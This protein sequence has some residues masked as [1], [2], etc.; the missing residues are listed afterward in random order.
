M[1]KAL[2]LGN[3]NILVG[4]DHVGQVRDFYFPYIG[5]ENQVGGH[6]VHR[7]GVYVDGTL[8]WLDDSSWEVVVSSE[9][10]SLTGVVRA[11]NRT[12]GVSL[13]TS[14]VVYNERN[15]F[16]RRVTIKNLQGVRR[17]IRLFFGQQFEL[18]E[19]HRAH[20][21]YYD[22]ATHSI[23]H[24]RGKRVFLINAR[25]DGVPFDDYSTG[26]FHAEGKEGTHRDAED[27]ILAKNP[28]EHG[29]ADSVIG[30]SAE[31]GPGES[32]IASYW[33]CVAKSHRYAKRL[34][35]QVLEK[36]PA[37]MM[38]TTQDYWKAWLNRQHFNFQG[39]SPEVISLFKKS[40]L[41]IRA[42]ADRGGALIASSDSDMMQQGGKDNY[43]Y[44]WH[45]DGAYSAL[46]LDRAGDFTVC[47]RF[48][49]FS[50]AV[51]TDDGYF[52]HK[53]SPDRSL[54]SS[55][56]GWMDRSSRTPELPIQEDET[57][58]VIWSL[59]QHYERTR[60]LEFIEELYNPLIRK[61]AEFMV[62]YRDE[63]TGLPLP[64]HDL[65]EERYGVHTYTAASVYGALIAASRFASL[66][67]KAKSESRF[68]STA[69]EI[70]T[71]ILTHLWSEERGCFAR[72][73]WEK[74]GVL[75]RDDTIDA[76][77]AYGML[78][79]GVL[80]PHDERLARAFTATKRALSVAT[81][82]GGIARYEG[83]RYYRVGADLPGNPW[84]VTTLWL[85]EYAIASARGDDDLK[86]A[87]EIFEWVVS[88]AGTGGILPEQVHPYSG[89][90]LSAA[91]LVWSH[92]AYINAVLS[93]L[94][95]LEA[96][97]L[98]E[99]CDP[100]NVRVPIFSS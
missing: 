58:T 65:W 42:H 16:L 51:I 38:K 14:D 39:L 96:L 75:V 37:H 61:A 32:R 100:L 74:E 81:S 2:T 64:S 34:N 36:S 4:L 48:F 12:L 8:A 50:K 7:V 79:F 5:L 99:V 30:L 57:A 53:Y 47:Q 71:A 97:G 56:H 23:V 88:R 95:R 28:I 25:L 46:A 55:W 60:D 18:Y 33:V 17:T 73:L 22:P 15:I 3:G 87:R 78:V 49:Q 1:P 82:I 29:S 13:E 67:G 43:C 89:M 6:F 10:E 68:I 70:K 85:A 90:G 72:S 9:K 19:S 54:G 44:M 21:A 59:W 62:S 76:A 66:L 35:E 20:T 93:Y 45:R 77:S 98:C 31:Y 69:E 41:N 11:E 80:D 26:V 84:I 40:L 27:G 92:A 94:D 52:M 86:Q 24:Y 83:D 91:P 63:R